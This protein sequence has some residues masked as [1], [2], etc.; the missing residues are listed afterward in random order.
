MGRAAALIAP[1]SA[2]LTWIA[3]CIL[4]HRPSVWF[5]VDLGGSVKA[6]PTHR[7]RLL[8]VVD[9]EEHVIT[10]LHWTTLLVANY[11]SIGIDN[12]TFEVT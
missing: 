7:R 9:L 5:F 2:G 1:I 11:G 8:D 10:G 6:E 3:A 4:R 12:F